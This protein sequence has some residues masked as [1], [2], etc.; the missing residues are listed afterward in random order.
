MVR[1]LVRL[2][3]I[4]VIVA[5]ALVVLEYAELL[6]PVDSTDGADMAP[7]LAACSGRGLAEGFTY[8]I[9]DPRQ[10]EVVA[11]HAARTD[12]GEIVPD[13]DA[14]DV[15]LALRVVAEPGD[16]VVAKRDR[17]VYVNDVKLDDVE[18]AP[19]D[20]VTVPNE[21]YFVLGDN[22]SSAVDSR[23]FGPILENT[24]FARVRVVFWPLRDFSFRMHTVQGAPPGEIDCD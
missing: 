6:V 14:R 2:L 24:I 16:V 20:P 1:S 9:R 17:R 23:T 8:R 10:G 19:F 7:T 13:K 22:R 15:T 18:T 3:T 4:L 11:I 21:Q 5:A 12:E